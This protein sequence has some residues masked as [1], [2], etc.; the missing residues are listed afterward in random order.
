MITQSLILWTT[1]GV[2][3][4]SFTICLFFKFVKQRENR[5]QQNNTTW[6]DQLV[7]CSLLSIAVSSSIG[8][9]V[10]PISWLVISKLINQG[11]V[12]DNLLAGTPEIGLFFALV[13][14]SIII[15]AWAFKSFIEYLK[16]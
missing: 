6:L 3:A 13:Q 10:L 12:E 4:L 16:G 2:F 14:G 15:A 8:L 7:R 9:L 1:T 5:N 11:P